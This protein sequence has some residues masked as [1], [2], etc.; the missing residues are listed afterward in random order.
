VSTVINTIADAIET[1]SREVGGSA[2]P[3]P[4]AAEF[5]VN[6]AGSRPKAGGTGR[7]LFSEDT[8][9]VLIF[10]NGAVIRLLATVTPGQLIFLTNLATKEEVV[11]EVLRKRL[12]RPAGCYVE[13][14]FTEKKKGFWGTPPAPK[15]AANGPETVD[16]LKKPLETLVSEVQELLA[17]KP[18]PLTAAPSVEAGATTRKEASAPAAVRGSE[19]RTKAGTAAP[20][21][22][23]ETKVAPVEPNDS[24]DELLPKPELDFSSARSEVNVKKHDP[25]L[26]HKPIP[27]IGAKSRKVMWTMMLLI[28]LG[29]GVRYGHWFDSW[30]HGKSA[31]VTP[32]RQTESVP[33]PVPNKAATKNDV[34]PGTNEAKEKL[35]AG[36]EKARPENNPEQPAVRASESAAANATEPGANGGG[37]RMGKSETSAKV[38]AEESP[39]G[40]AS[41]GEGPTVP[42]KLTRSVNPVYPAEAMQSFITGNVK[43]EVVVEPTG[44]VG[45]VKVVSGPTQ[46]KAA[47]VEALKKYEFTPATRGGKAVASKVMVTVKFWFNP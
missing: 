22:G 28:A 2:Q 46:L 41:V 26:L 29:A 34:A 33:Q 5:P 21:E 16:P 24:I 11:C 19:S 38:E 20:S 7:E 47:A 14:Q 40:G 27:E 31:G 42:A 32:R 43:A 12:L 17:K 35:R 23:Q 13:L 44:H 15:A 25:A 8:E 30:T 1:G 6:A 3:N 45:E 4:T 37:A 36:G 18:A 9:T 39:K 10:E